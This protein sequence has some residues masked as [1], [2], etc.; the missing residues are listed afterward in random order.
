MTTRPP[1]AIRQNYNGI[2]DMC[3]KTSVPVSLTK[4]R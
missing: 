1:A 3:K 2:A 4:K